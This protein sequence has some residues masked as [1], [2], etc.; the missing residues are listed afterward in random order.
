MS[1]CT[2]SAQ[3]P[4][5]ERPYNGAFVLLQPCA[6]CICT[7]CAKRFTSP[8]PLCGSVVQMLTTLG[9][10]SSEAMYKV[11][12]DLLTKVRRRTSHT[13]KASKASKK[14]HASRRRRSKK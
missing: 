14:S 2:A 7:P 6:H 5:C 13:P 12:K 3:C 11:Q 1:T 8:C 4:I 9:Q 10:F